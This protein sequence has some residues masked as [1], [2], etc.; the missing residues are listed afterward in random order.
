MNWN[1]R[2]NEI[3]ITCSWYLIYISDIL[4]NIYFVKEKETI[5]DPDE[6][7][8]LRCTDWEDQSFFQFCKWHMTEFNVTHEVSKVYV[9]MCIEVVGYES[10]L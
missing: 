4:M 8:K 2:D 1:H 10:R 6:E 3:V 7:R 5:L 9:I